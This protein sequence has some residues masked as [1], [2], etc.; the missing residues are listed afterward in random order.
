[1]NDGF[2]GKLNGHNGNGEGIQVLSGVANSPSDSRL[3]YKYVGDSAV[4]HDFI[5]KGLDGSISDGGSRVW[6]NLRRGGMGGIMMN[7]EDEGDYHYYG[8]DSNESHDGYEIEESDEG[9]VASETSEIHEEQEQEQG[10][11]EQE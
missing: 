5:Y 6:G 3:E 2:M 7:R 11:G 8:D 9:L 1:M 10:E 4:K